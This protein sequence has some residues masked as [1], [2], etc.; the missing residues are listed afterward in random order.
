MRSLFKKIAVG[1]FLLVFSIWAFI[2]FVLP[3][4]I[5]SDFFVSKI[6]DLIFNKFEN[7]FYS[8]NSKLK[9][10]P[11]FTFNF[12]SDEIIF[13]NK[14]QIL[15]LRGVELI[16]SPFSKEKDKI[17]VGEIFFQKTGVNLENK[18]NGVKNNFLYYKNLKNL[19][20]FF[21]QKGYI[22]LV[23]DKKTSLKFKLDNLLFKKENSRKILSLNLYGT[24]D[25]L[26]EDIKIKNNSKFYFLDDGIYVTDLKIFLFD[27]IA[28]IK[29][30]IYDD[31]SGEYFLIKGKNLPAFDIEQT[32]LLLLK[33][34]KNKK[35]FIENF[36]NFK[37]KLNL[38]LYYEAK[39]LFGN[40][41]LANFGANT[42]P[43]NIP[44]FFKNADFIF[45]GKEIIMKSDG[46]F[47]GEKAKADLYITGLF[48]DDL[49]TSGSISSYVTNNFAK[50]YIDGLFIKG[51]VFLNVDYYVKNGIVGVI[52]KASVAPYSDVYYLKSRLG[53]FKLKRTIIAYTQKKDDIIKLLKYSYLVSNN[54]KETEIING[55][56][57]FSKRNGKKFA[58]DKISLKT[59]KDAPVSLLGFIESNL[60]GGKFNGEIEYD[61]IHSKLNGSLILSHSH[62]K[63]FLIEKAAVF[64]GSDTISVLAHGMYQNEIYNAVIELKNSL[65]ENLLIYNFDIYL[66]KYVLLKTSSNKKRFKPFFKEIKVKRT[67]NV[68]KFKLRLDKFVKD[69]ILI[70][71]LV[72]TGS[73]NNNVLRFKMQNALFANG[74]LGA[75]GFVD[76]NKKT[77]EINFSAEDIDA[78]IASYQVFNIKDHIKGLAGAKLRLFI[79]NNF[80]DYFGVAVFDV[81]NGA[82][83]K[84]GTKEFMVKGSRK[85]QPFKF[86]LAKIIKIDKNLEL[87]PESDIKGFFNFRGP[88]ISDINIIVQND[89]ISFFIEGEYN[90][91]T[92]YSRLNLWGRYDRELE[93]NVSIFHIPMGF[94]YNF[95]FKIKDK[96]DK[97]FEKLLKIPS[98]KNQK[99]D[100]KTF[101]VQAEGNINDTKNLKFKFTDIR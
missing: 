62:F 92:Q 51:K 75:F 52:Y 6:S 20:D 16:L 100:T 45:S 2:V 17:T 91:K 94:L 84:F 85:K 57:L 38:N 48:T 58:I 32:V 88:I 25:Y 65:D 31:F 93:K 83:T 1:F 5:N 24:S 90:T 59:M 69:N 82:L 64:A 68:E 9:I 12:S 18:G 37:G 53:L 3:F 71:N 98:I 63:G 4:I 47:G 41:Q 42:V 33:R 73:V 95:I 26:L 23:S 50:K 15:N 34:H 11:D 36:K 76:F 28:T 56:G 54:K 87:C 74:F 7:V 22:N 39:E 55:S 14:T 8:K 10:H 60:R 79:N 40:V 49:I 27:S 13:L 66:K 78:K 77:S 61:F 72:L 46:L 19:P 35:Y 96:K 30:K 44:L 29:G 21:I 67:I 80:K 86:S 43:L 70:K 81:K 101:S 99:D 89:L 97:Y